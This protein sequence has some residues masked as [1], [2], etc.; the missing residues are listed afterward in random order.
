[1]L[2]FLNIIILIAMF[3]FFIFSI[4][5]TAFRLHTHFCSIPF[6]TLQIIVAI[7][8]IGSFFALIITSRFSSQ[9]VSFI[10]ILSGYV[11]LF[12]IFLFIILVIAHIIHRIWSFPLLLSGISALAVAFIITIVGAILGASFFVKET[13]IKISNLEN[14]LTIMQISDVHI[15]HHRRHDYLAK[16]VEETNKRNPDLVL[17]TGDLIDAAPALLQ[18][19]LEPLS[20]FKAP[21]YFVE[22]NHEID[23]VRE[24]AL[25][26]IAQQGVHILHNEV[27]ETHGIQLIGLEY[28][29]ADENTFDM[30]PSEKTDTIKSVLAQ[31]SIKS[32]VPSI[33]IHHSPVGIQYIEST[34]IDLM[35]SGHTHAGQV[36]PF[37]LF[38]KLSFPFNSGLYQQ[39]KTKI[40]VSNGAGT[41]MVRVRLG[42][43]NE[44]NLLKLI[45]ND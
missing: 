15:G 1:M 26:L 2:V 44:I 9:F 11:L 45:P 34:G 29:K 16:I 40:F 31:L 23:V 18:G 25:N 17:I 43:F 22:G 41:F 42:S 32:D 24:R 30:H 33:L 12:I 38:S 35:L 5:Y 14:E 27:T 6:W 37:S 19:V 13:E 10:N 4:W 20:N 21:V 8:A 36:F 28:M 39:G 7:C 3:A